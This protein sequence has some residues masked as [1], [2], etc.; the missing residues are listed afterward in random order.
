MPMKTYDTFAGWFEDQTP[1]HR[2][3][4]T[5]LRKLVDTVAPGLVKGSRWTNGVWLKGDLPII[6]IHTEPDHVQLGFFAGVSLTD[7]KK[8][9]RGKG[10][11]V[12][13]IRVER[14]EDIDEAAF[15]TMIRKAVRAPS[16]K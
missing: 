2:K 3:I 11:Q 15:A 6:Y 4:I 13:H 14:I 1:Q 12:R 16:Y 7:P 5:K 9:L 8:L 10:K